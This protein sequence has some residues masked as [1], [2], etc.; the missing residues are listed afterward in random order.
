MS[1]QK[2]MERLVNEA[3]DAMETVREKLMDLIELNPALGTIVN[4]SASAFV[5]ANTALEDILSA[6][7]DI[8][9]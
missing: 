3:M 1:I 9:A 6:V 5:K 4:D 2:D 8:D 7:E